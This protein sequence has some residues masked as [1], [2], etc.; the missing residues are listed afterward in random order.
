MGPTR[1]GRQDD[2]VGLDAVRRG[3]VRQLEG[4][5]HLAEHP[6]D[7][8]PADAD[9]GDTPTACPQ[10]LDDP[11]EQRRAFGSIGRRRLVD[12]RAE[13]LVELDTRIDRVRRGAG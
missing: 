8:R 4:G 5:E 6:G 13:Q 7:A 11:P 10:V 9:D 2:V 3:L 1:R 12:G